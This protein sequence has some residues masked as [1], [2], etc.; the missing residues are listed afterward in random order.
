VDLDAEFGSTFLTIRMQ[1]AYAP[2]RHFCGGILFIC[3]IGGRMARRRILASGMARQ[4]I[5][6]AGMKRYRAN[7][8]SVDAVAS[9]G[10]LCCGIQSTRV[11]TAVLL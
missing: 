1:E 11:E 10:F 5:S 9:V 6:A 2:Q 7:Y 8:R 3:E 4:I